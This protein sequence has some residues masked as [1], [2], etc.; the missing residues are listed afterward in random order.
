LLLRR[1]QVDLCRG[2]GREAKVSKPSDDEAERLPRPIAQALE[3]QNRKL[4]RV[5]TKV[6][7][8]LDLLQKI[9]TRLDEADDEFGAFDEFDDEMDEPVN[10]AEITKELEKLSPEEFKRQFVEL[11]ATLQ[12]AAKVAEETDEDEE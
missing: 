4:E 2:E 9:D 3:R 10:I 1:G 12:A 11:V 8:V 6:D 5:E 7:R